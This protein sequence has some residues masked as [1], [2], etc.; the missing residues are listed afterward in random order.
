M[1]NICTNRVILLRIVRGVL[2]ADGVAE[3]PESTT[4]YNWNELNRRQTLLW[5]LYGNSAREREVPSGN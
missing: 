2:S 4:S 3:E 5:A 1:L